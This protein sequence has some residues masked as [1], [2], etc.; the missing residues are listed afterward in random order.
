M[1]RRQLLTSLGVAAGVSLV[2]AKEMRAAPLLDK[3]LFPPNVPPALKPG[4]KVGIPAPASGIT[5][6]DFERKAKAFMKVLEELSLVPVLAK[7]VLA[8]SSYLAAPDE[9]RAAEFMEFVNNK[10]IG[11]IICMRGGYGVMR[12]LPML[13]FEAIQRNPKI[14][15]GFSDIT[16]LVNTVYQRCNLVA[17]H[18]PMAA[19][20]FDDF[21][22]QWFLPLVYP[23]SLGKAGFEPLTYADARLVAYSSGKARGR[24]VG[25]NLTLITAL[26][27]TPYDI[28]TDG[29]VLFLEDVGE[30]SYKVD[31]MMTQLWLAGK[32][33]RCAAIVLGQFTEGE[34]A[35]F[36]VTIEDV[37]RS[38]LA[39]L[40]IPVL[41]NFP[42]GHVKSNFTM[43]IGV[44]AE[45]DADARKIRLL[46]PS[47]QS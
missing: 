19:T 25:G 6:E 46:E 21:T 11:A 13:D 39:P 2:H 15:C 7:S 20:E 22:R 26:M 36:S 34:D 33:Q 31:R 32:L 47:V 4:T 23:E 45:V 27:G 41:A 42:L 3:R 35:N 38:R 14:I 43:P 5:K 9:V 10:E 44:L 24:I 40:N 16:A 12:I 8:G 17:F 18:G 1:R 30:K 37:L 29:A 28:N